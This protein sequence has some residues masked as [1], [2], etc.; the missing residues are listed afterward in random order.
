EKE[1]FEIAQERSGL[2]SNEIL[3]ID[4]DRS[5][6][7]AAGRAGWHTMSFDAFNPEESIASVR[8]ALEIE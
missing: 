7:M 4:D 1:I 5:N 2:E 3:L 8:R 6:L